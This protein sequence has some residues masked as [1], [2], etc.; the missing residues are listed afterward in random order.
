M[1]S[2]RRL[3]ILAA[4]FAA[5]AAPALA[6]SPPPMFTPADEAAARAMIDRYFAAF[7]AKDYG[8]FRQ[9]FHAPFVTTRERQL[10][11]LPTLDAVAQ[12]YEAIRNPLDQAD[13]SSSQAS[14]VRVEPLSGA[15]ALAHVH[16]RRMKKDGTLFDEGAEVLVLAKVDGTWKISGVLGEDLRQFRAR[17]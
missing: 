7:S 11:V 8:V 1:L 16:W 13:Y 6:Q 12:M 10:T 9:V 14:E 2:R 17:N 5:V 15:S 4:S 3:A